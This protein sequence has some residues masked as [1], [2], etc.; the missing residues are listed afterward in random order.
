MSKVLTERQKEFL[1]N[2]LTLGEFMKKYRYKEGSLAGIEHY[3]SECEQW[4]NIAMKMIND[5]E[6][7]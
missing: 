1:R 6:V 7:N 4:R 2:P 5:G 3:E